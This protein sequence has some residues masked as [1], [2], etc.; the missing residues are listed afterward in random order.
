MANNLL[1]LGLPLAIVAFL[2]QAILRDLIFIT[3]GVGKTI[4]LVSE[5]PYTCHRI[6]DPHLSACEDMFLSD[7]TRQLFL[8]CSDPLARQQWMPNVAQFNHSGRSMNDAM[9]AMDIDRPN[10]KGGFEYRVL[11]TIGYPVDKHDDS[12]LHLVGLTGNDSPNTI[13]VL[14]VNAKPS[15]DPQTG[16]LLDNE[17]SGANS[18]IEKFIT[19]PAATTLKHVATYHH[20]RIATPNNIATAPGMPGFYITND[21]GL[22]KTGYMH[23][24]STVFGLGDVTYCDTSTPEKLNCEKLAG[25]I[26]FPNG[27]L[28]HPAHDLLYV[29]SSANGNIRVYRPSYGSGAAIPVLTKIHD[30]PI[31]YPIDNLSLDSRTGDIYVPCLPKA[32]EM[33]AAG[34]DPYNSFPP[35]TVFRVKRVE[36]GTGKA[37]FKYEVEKVLED[38]GGNGAVLPGTTTV[39][40]DGRTGRLFLSGE[41]S[42]FPLCSLRSSFLFSCACMCLLFIVRRRPALKRARV[43]TST[44]ASAEALSHTI[45]L[46]SR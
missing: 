32:L 11:K 29:P 1:K 43:E 10:G 15:R 19:G 27:L 36:D 12:T 30:I 4:E 2:Y 21:H 40:R 41:S 31:S 35:T 16:V 20:T 3:L 22:H 38:V 7:A 23:V 37:N 46:A 39:V 14:L 18:T 8:A 5:F 42:C 6:E 44:C 34:S 45:G 33:L 24:L 25:G 26:S 28:Y 13:E 9:I 17:V